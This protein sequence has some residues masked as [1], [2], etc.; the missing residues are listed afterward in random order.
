MRPP[1]AILFEPPNLGSDYQSTYIVGC[2]SLTQSK[3]L[4]LTVVN[5]FSTFPFAFPLWKITSSSVINCLLTLIAIFGTPGFIHFDRGTQ[6]VSSEFQIICCQNGVA[7]SKQRPKTL[8]ASAK[9]LSSIRLLINT[10]TKQSSQDRFFCFKRG[11]LLIRPSRSAPWLRANTPAYVWKIVRAKYQAP[12]VPVQISEV[13]FPHLARVVFGDGRLDTVSTSD[14]SRRPS[15][16][17]NE[18]T[19]RNQAVSV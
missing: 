17:D 11:E 3:E 6:F 18:E 15:D 16:V 4:L 13:I 12:V 7:T 10:V 14:F 2:K 1:A 8:R 5:K 9:T 19:F